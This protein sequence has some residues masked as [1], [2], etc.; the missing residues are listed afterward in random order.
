[1]VS[2]LLMACTSS[3]SEPGP[4]NKEKVSPSSSESYLRTIEEAEY[5]LKN[6]LLDLATTDTRGGGTI[7]Q[8]E[9]SYSVTLPKS[10][11][12]RS[13]NDSAALD[14]HIFNFSNDEGF[15]IMAANK[16]LPSLLALTESGHLNPD[17]ETD[18]PGLQCMLSNLCDMN[19]M[20]TLGLP[21]NGPEIIQPRPDEYITVNGPITNNI[22][23]P[24]GMCPVRWGQWAP[25]NM[26]CPQI[27]KEKAPTGCGATAIAQ[28]MAIYKFPSSY[29]QTYFNWDGMTKYTFGKYCTASSKDNI[30]D[31][32]ILL[33]NS[34]NLNMNYGDQSGTYLDNVPR[35]L[36]NFGYSNIGP[37]SD[38]NATNVLKDL[39][40]GKPMLISGYRTKNEDK[41][42]GVTYQTSYTD[43]HIWLLHG[44]LERTYYTYTY[45]N[46]E[47]IDSHLVRSWYVLCNFGWDGEAD[48][49]YYS[50]MFNLN[51]RA[52]RDDLLTPNQS[53]PRDSIKNWNFQ[54]KLK[55]LS[56]SL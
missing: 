8:I 29:K 30:A 44:L 54:Y 21:D 43:G 10:E 4:I 17:L 22:I 40:D 25:Y 5:D 7:K 6:I 16:A 14:I 26:K 27:G 48:G 51:Y 42:L 13:D 47:L 11:K 31:L 52:L 55:T 53:E 49:Y 15:A 38:F 3:M 37:I 32:M 39:K 20:T 45:C 1:M 34:E 18:N 28:L 23:Y 46:S 12:T 41:I 36:K 35:T 19:S 24:G 9:S 33:G 50:G 2:A 56:V